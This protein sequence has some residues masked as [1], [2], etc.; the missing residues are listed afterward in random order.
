M[1]FFNGWAFWLMSLYFNA[2]NSENG[3]NGIIQGPAHLRPTNQAGSVCF[4]NAFDELSCL[5]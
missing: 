1:H 4:S 3:Q 2:I 5:L